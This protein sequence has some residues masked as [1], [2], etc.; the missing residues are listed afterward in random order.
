MDID[1]LLG[2]SSANNALTNETVGGVDGGA[3]SASNVATHDGTGDTIAD[4]DAC[5]PTVATDQ[6]KANT[7]AR[8][9]GHALAA[10]GKRGDVGGT[11]ASSSARVPA[12]KAVASK[13]PWID[14]AC[15][16]RQILI[17]IVAFVISVIVVSV[18]RPQPPLAKGPGG[19]DPLP[20]SVDHPGRVASTLSSST[21]P[22]PSIRDEHGRYSRA[23]RSAITACTSLPRHAAAGAGTRHTGAQAHGAV[24]T[25]RSHPGDLGRH[26]VGFSSVTSPSRTAGVA[27]ATSFFFLSH[28]ASSL[29]DVIINSHNA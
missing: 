13:R 22:C 19:S 17:V 16:V 9:A 27:I 14:A 5:E 29:H 1:R 28:L 20:L 18:M 11:C 24:D 12:T 10:T 21:A 3:T 8:E 7:A 2:L 6:N 15:L 23:A 4:C 26:R 25:D